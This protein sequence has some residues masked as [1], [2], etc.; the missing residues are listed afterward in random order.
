MFQMMG[1]IVCGVDALGRV[2]YWKGLRGVIPLIAKLLTFSPSFAASGCFLD[3]VIVSFMFS[4]LAGNDVGVGV[5]VV[6]VFR[7]AVVGLGKLRHHE[8][9]SRDQSGY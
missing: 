7:V 2:V 6:V 9:D 8:K 3:M 5:G 4:V 1:C